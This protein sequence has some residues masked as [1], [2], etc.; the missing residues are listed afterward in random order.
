[1]IFNLAESK[2]DNKELMEQLEKQAKDIQSKD[3]ELIFLRDSLRDLRDC[4]VAS[5][6]AKR[7]TSS[8]K[9]KRH[10]SLDNFQ[11]SQELDITLQSPKDSP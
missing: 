4:I 8:L 9:K 5:S 10:R 6:S 2:E 3:L 11:S 7:E 1:M